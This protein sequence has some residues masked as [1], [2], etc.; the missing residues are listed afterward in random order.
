MKIIFYV[1]G[2]SFDGNTI[3]EGKSLGGSESAGYYV[4]REMGKRGHEVIVFSNIEKP[5]KADNVTYMPIGRPTEKHPFGEVFG[6]YAACVPHDVLIAQRIPGFFTKRYNSKINLWWTHDLALKR[7]QQQFDSQ[8]PFVDQVLV[9]SEY[10][11]EQTHSVYGHKKDFISILPNSVDVDLFKDLPSPDDKISSKT[12][13]YS[14]RPERGLENL[15]GEGG[16]MERLFHV[17]P[18]V[19][20][21]VCGYDNTTEQMA[22]YYKQLWTRCQQLPNVELYGPQSKE[23]LANLMKGAWLHIYP[24]SF[25]ETSCITAMEEQMAGTPFIT[26]KTGALTETLDDAGVYWV[27]KVKETGEPDIEKFVQA[28]TRIYRSNKLWMD[29]H[30]KALKKG[31]QFTTEKA[32]DQLESTIDSIFEEKTSSKKRLAKHLIHNS[33]IMAVKELIKRHPEELKEENEFIKKEYGKV[34]NTDPRVFY[35]EIADYNTNQIKNNHNIGNDEYHLSMPRVRP[36]LQMLST[37]SGEHKVLDYGCCV[38]HQTI[39]YARAFP[40]LEFVGCDIS[41]AQTE[42]G[43]AYAKKHGIK[44]VSFIN[45]NHPSEIK[46][47]FDA[48]ICCE[49]MEHVEDYIGFLDGIETLVDDGSKIMVTLPVGPHEEVRWN[50]QTTREHLHHFEEQ[51][52]KEIFINKQDLSITFIPSHTNNIGEVLGNNAVQWIR[53]DNQFKEID[54]DRKFKIQAPRETLA[55][56]MISR[57]DGLTIG[58]TLQS[59]REIADEIIIGFDGESG[60][61]WEIAK[62]FGAKTFLIEG[63]RS[64]GFDSARNETIKKAK[65]DW[66]LWIDDDENL[67]WPNQIVPM[68]RY[69]QYDSYA[70]HQHHFSA[71]PPGIMKTDLP[72]RFFR[73]HI[74]IEFF[75]FVH[76]HPEVEMNKGAGET[77]LLPHNLIAICHNGYE[78]EQ[79]RRDRF[80]RNWPLMVEDNKRNPN[81][82]LGQFLFL[83][84]LIHLNRFEIEKNGGNVTE[85]MI[86]RCNMVL[87]YFNKLIA[88]KKVRLVVDSLPYITEATNLVSGKGSGYEVEFVVKA[89]HSGLGD[90]IDGTS[91][92]LVH[93][94]FP[95]KKLAVKTLNLIAEDKLN[96]LDQKY[97]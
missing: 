52:I 72:C 37:L 14:S 31:K 33:D 83:R 62:D 92:N 7:S 42:I 28:V 77:A 41:K 66:I 87:N 51:D 19:K 35:D 61:G 85:E 22:P 49:V 73:N 89:N 97:I 74:G 50:Q 12:M 48:V 2:M 54:Y 71:D 45:A 91:S 65:A 86:N 90:K 79:V 44:N 57:P 58:K 34:F 1:A 81:R 4:A 75:G 56:C 16:I 24:T 21:I 18:E 5:M 68:L 82:E 67:I 30:K 47:K 70:I 94:V 32:V 20:L 23:N 46:E 36:V 55:V 95:S 93:C 60:R 8:L 96:N 84:D 27:D 64:Q 69:N 80:L 15:V 59:V 29:L 53:D 39:A 78:N 76:E 43:E 11:K 63:P 3:N 13:I 6:D 25:E 38:G 10:H 17:D 88:Q 9:V 40:S 26:T